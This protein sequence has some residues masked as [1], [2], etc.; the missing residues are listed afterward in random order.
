V[1]ELNK[2]LSGAAPIILSDRP[3][4]LRLGAPALLLIAFVVV[5]LIGSDYWLGVIFVPFL[6]LSL[7]GV[8][9]NLLTGYAGQTSLGSGG[10]MAVG[11]F[12]TFALD[13]I[14]R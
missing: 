11:A 7:A 14:A 5:P 8:G 4:R 6:I 1:S 3:L 2:T 10:F 13:A 9:L 12:A